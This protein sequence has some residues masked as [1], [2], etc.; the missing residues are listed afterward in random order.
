M[1]LSDYKNGDAIDLLADIMGPLVVITQDPVFQAKWN[2]GK[3]IFLA[4]QYALKEHKQ[5]V[6]ELVAAL[7]REDPETYE[8]DI[9][10]LLAD[11]I[12]LTNDPL[13]QSV[14]PVQSQ[15][16]GQEISGSATANIVASAT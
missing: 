14:F 10:S 9:A 7:H 2:S 5:S 11:L 3:P 8:F 1:R 13:V 15:N 12:E 6:I 4:L 16:N